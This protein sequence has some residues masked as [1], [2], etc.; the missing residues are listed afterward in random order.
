[1]FNS[2][3]APFIILIIIFGV[4]IGFFRHLLVKVLAILAI[5]VALFIFYPNLLTKLAELVEFVRRS[6]S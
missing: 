5:E 4:L 3:I 6:L 2:S 1:M